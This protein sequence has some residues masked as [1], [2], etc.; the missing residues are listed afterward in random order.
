LKADDWK[1]QFLVSIR[2]HFEIEQLFANQKYA[3]WGLPFY[4]SESRMP[5]FDAAFETLL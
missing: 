5:E 3:V 1:E 4:N 2:E